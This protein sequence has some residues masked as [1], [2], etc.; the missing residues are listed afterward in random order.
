[1]AIRVP[2]FEW[3]NAVVL[4]LSSN[5]DGDEEDD[6]MMTSSAMHDG[7]E[8]WTGGARSTST[9]Q[10]SRG[11]P[12]RER[13]EGATQRRSEAVPFVLQ[14]ALKNSE[15]A[16]LRVNAEVT[17]LASELRQVCVCVSGGV[18]PGV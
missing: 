14:V 9:A 15:G 10:K 3:S 18:L 8:A 6:W 12:W 7:S 11:Q 16:T 13:I 1:M 5:V 2:G 4:P 17:F